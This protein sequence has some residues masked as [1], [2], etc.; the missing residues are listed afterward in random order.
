MSAMS[1]IGQTPA[2]QLSTVER[3]IYREQGLVRPAA[4]LDESTVS[5]MRELLEE[6]LAATPG[7]RPESL[8]CPHIEGSNGLSAEITGRW[9]DLCTRAELVDLVADVL[10]PDIV[11][12]GSQLFCKP[13][14][15][16]LEVP[17][18]QD[19]H[20][21]PIRPLATC[22]VWIAIDDVDAENGAM[23]FVPGSQRTRQLYAHEA[24]PSEESALD[25]QLVPE[26]VDLARAEV[27]ALSAGAL[28]LHDVYL[29]HGSK[30]NRSAR[31]RA[32]YVIRYM[33]ATSHYDREQAR[34]GVNRIAA[35]L[36][37]RPLFLL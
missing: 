17:W 21:W 5:M 19:G 1:A 26:H 24:Q 9:L 37:D 3:R 2:G 35:N 20:F 4:C 25:A 32:G 29:V 34:A 36:A 14:R 22:T 33:P 27:D 28:S 8:V 23:L 6:T 11:L 7:T 10:G 15:T 30:P 12:W 18:H 13:A 31:R 16:G